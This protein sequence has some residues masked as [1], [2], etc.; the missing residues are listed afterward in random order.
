MQGDKKRPQIALYNIQC[1]Q[2]KQLRYGLHKQVYSRSVA[3]G[4]TPR[5]NIAC[6]SIDSL[7]VLIDNNIPIQPQGNTQQLQDFDKIF[8]QIKKG[9]TALTAGDYELRRPNS[10]FMNYYKKLQGATF[11][12]TF[13]LGKNKFL[14]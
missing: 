12:N 14:I 1:L 5:D 8:I 7:V 11:E 4:A 10:Y 9:K 2:V 13:E 3:I 6:S